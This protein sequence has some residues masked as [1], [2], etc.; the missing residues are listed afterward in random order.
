MLIHSS[1]DSCALVGSSSCCFPSRGYFGGHLG[2]AVEGLCRLVYLSRLIGPW[3]RIYSLWFSI[4]VSVVVVVIK[5]GV[6]FF[7]DSFV[8]SHD[9]RFVPD[10]F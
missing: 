9:A 1:I 4:A 2:A 5:R 6:L 7:E 8:I 10:F 3:H